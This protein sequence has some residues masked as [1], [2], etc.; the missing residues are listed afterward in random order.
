[1]PAPQR[2]RPVHTLTVT[3][4]E[5]ITPHM[6]RVWAG[7]PGLAA[8]ADNGFTDNYVKLL[9]FPDGRP[10]GPLDAAELR[11]SGNLVTRTYTI[12]HRTPD[13]LAIDFVHHGDTGL[14]GPWAAAVRPGEEFSFMGPGGAYRPDDSADWHLFA[15]D[16]AALPAIGAAIESLPA[17]AVGVAFLEVDDSAEEQKFV[18]EAA[19]DIRWVAPGT[20]VDAVREYPLPAGRGHAFVHGETGAV[21]QLRSVL[22]DVDQLSI[23]GYWRRGMAEP[24]FQA[25]K[26]TDPV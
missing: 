26:R 20:L 9:F 18:T 7:G 8:V 15:G 5:W 24:E 3:R 2:T 10:E 11:A 12:R 13:E 17:H 14:A 16:A 1:M 6:V 23:S 22:A 25:A 19:V 4:T 21:K